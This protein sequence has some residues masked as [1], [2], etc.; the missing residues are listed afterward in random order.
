MN[1]VTCEVPQGS[2]LGPLFFALYINDIYESAGMDHVQLFADDTA[3]YMWHKNLTTLVEEIKLE[4]SH[5]Y[6][7]CVRNKLIIN[8]DKTHFVLFHTVNKPMP[9]NFLTIQTEF[10]SI[11]RVSFFK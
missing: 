5:L 3:L 8:R 7:W 4:L 2:I 1:A 9:M 10:M 6:M 11:D